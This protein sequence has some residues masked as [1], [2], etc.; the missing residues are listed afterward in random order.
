MNYQGFGFNKTTYNSSP[1]FTSEYDYTKTYPYNAVGPNSYSLDKPEFSSS[2]YKKIEDFN[3]DNLSNIEETVNHSFN[4]GQFKEILQANP[5][6]SHFLDDYEL[7]K[8]KTP[9]NYQNFPQSN[10]SQH[11]HNKSPSDIKSDMNMNIYS[12]YQKDDEIFQI[13][14]ANDANDLNRS[15]DI[16]NKLNFNEFTIQP[17]L[18]TRSVYNLVN[19]NK[20]LKHGPYSMDMNKD[21]ILDSDMQK[22]V[23]Y[24]NQPKNYNYY[25]NYM[26]ISEKKL[27]KKPSHHHHK[28]YSGDT[29]LNNMNNY[30]YCAFHENE[31]K[32]IDYVNVMDISKK[33]DNDNNKNFEHQP[34]IKEKTNFIDIFKKGQ[35]DK[36]NYSNINTMNISEP[37]GV[38][39]KDGIFI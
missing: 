2:N 32:N 29:G 20:P 11:S 27:E 16:K 33:N 34:I 10:I 9:Q 35:L 28:G 21:N 8:Q 15:G 18:E 5:P 23:F 38:K 1:N 12:T 4:S 36:P 7:S 30:N 17:D 31:K 3:K 14:D 26:N 19:E 24:D 13:L 37:V 25:D 22:D 6:K 39:G